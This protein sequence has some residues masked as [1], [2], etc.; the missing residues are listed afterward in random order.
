MNEPTMYDAWL[1]E[2]GPA[3]LVLREPL[4]PVE[5][6]DGV[7]FPATFAPAE[8]R[9]KFSG[10]YNI[11]VF[12]DDAEIGAVA[13]ALVRGGSLK[14]TIDLF[15]NSKNVCLVDSVGSQANRI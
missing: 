9:T 8:D 15:P 10:G 14:P 5:G 6:P 7:L 4:V 13:K 12:P 1:K 2:E 11:N 3:A